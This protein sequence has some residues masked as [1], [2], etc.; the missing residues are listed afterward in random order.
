MGRNTCSLKLLTYSSLFRS[1]CTES[2]KDAIA[3]ALKHSRRQAQTTYDRR[4][5]HD[6]KRLA[7]DYAQT[8]AATCTVDSET[9]S[10]VPEPGDFVALIEQG[11]TARRPKIL[12]AQVQYSAGK[13]VHLLWY[14]PIKGQTKCYKMKLDGNPWVEAISAL[15]PIQMEA[16]KQHGVYKLLTKPSQIYEST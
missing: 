15:T 11:S 5:A 1:E 2:L 8:S 7:I 16:T 4:T 9:T 3:S 12:V 14:E 10:Y 6:K 13:D